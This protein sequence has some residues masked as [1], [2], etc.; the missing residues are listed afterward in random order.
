METFALFCSEVVAHR[1]SWEKRESCL[2][3]IAHR[4]DNCEYCNYSDEI[5]RSLLG[6]N[7][8]EDIPYPQTYLWHRHSSC[9]DIQEGNVAEE[10]HSNS[11]EMCCYA[12]GITYA[13][14]QSWPC[15]S[16]SR[17]IFQVR[18]LQ[19]SSLFEQG[20]AAGW[21]KPWVCM[22]PD[23]RSPGTSYLDFPCACTCETVV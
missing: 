8:A 17:R 21:T 13:S 6:R 19:T 11:R 22:Q 14:W 9:L 10:A 23:D 5:L 3:D 12:S 4:G 2:Q 16:L 15:G 18:T 20:L 1:P 7:L